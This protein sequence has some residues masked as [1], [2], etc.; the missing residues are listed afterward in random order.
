MVEEAIYMPQDSPRHSE[1]SILQEVKRIKDQGKRA[2][3]AKLEGRHL[4]TTNSLLADN[5]ILA[6]AVELLLLRYY[7]ILERMAVDDEGRTD[8]NTPESLLDKLLKDES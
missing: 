5:A 8:T 1:N 3:L 4:N 7:G 6:A 2:V